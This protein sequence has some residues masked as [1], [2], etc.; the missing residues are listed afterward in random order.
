MPMRARGGD[1]SP[2]IFRVVVVLPTP[3][4]DRSRRVEMKK[5]DE[6]ASSHGMKY[7]EVSAQSGSGVEAGFEELY[8]DILHKGTS[9]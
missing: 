2:R 6:W 1:I 7:Y 8:R 4:S 3:Q 5:A 9:R